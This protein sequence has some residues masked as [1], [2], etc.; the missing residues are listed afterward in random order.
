MGSVAG[1]AEEVKTSSH[2]QS[3]LIGSRTSGGPRLY[4][5]PAL[6]ALIGGIFIYAGAL[7]AWDPVKFAN[8]IQ[9]FRILSWPVGVRLAFYLPW[10]EIVAGLALFI[11]W[12]RSG[13]VAILTSLTAIFIVATVSAHAR[14]IDLECGCFGAASK[15][16][17]FAS[18][19][20]VLIGMLAGLV[21]LW[22]WNPPQSARHG[23]L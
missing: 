1:G 2:V 21:L 16:W 23:S 18:H 6:G 4:V 12:M 22:F 5:V 3:P 17:S 8:D 14:G 10:V 19:M 7:K 13:A 20:A 11:G 9:N 15:N